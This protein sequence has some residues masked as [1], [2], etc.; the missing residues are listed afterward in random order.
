ATTHTM[1]KEANG[2]RHT[3]LADPN[4]ELATR[5]G[6]PATACKRRVRAVNTNRK[7]LLD[8]DG[9]AIFVERPMTLARWTMVVDRNGKI[10]SLRTIVHPETDSEDA[11]K[12]VAALS[13]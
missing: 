2:L 4:G 8:S 6:V 9:K 3:L 11:L 13:K 5:L 12:I 1:F 10:A 7:P